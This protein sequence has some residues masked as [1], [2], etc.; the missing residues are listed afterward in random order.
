MSR[1]HR[2]E[3][4]WCGGQDDQTEAGAAPDSQQRM[5]VEDAVARMQW[6]CNYVGEQKQVK[7]E[8]SPSF[9]DLLQVLLPFFFAFFCLFFVWCCLFTK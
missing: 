7:L 8:I 6:L 2:H 4:A 3:R 9:H 1:I 5:T